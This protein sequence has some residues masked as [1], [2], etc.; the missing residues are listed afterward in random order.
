MKVLITGGTGNLGKEL[1]VLFREALAPTRA[2]L[3]ICN[4]EEIHASIAKTVPEVV[5]HTAALTG[6][7]ACEQNQRLAY[8][9]NVLGSKYL[10]EA[11]KK[12][13]RD[14]FFVHISTACV[15]AGDRGNY[16][17]S[18]VPYPKNFYSLTKLLSEFEVLHSGLKRWL[19]VRTNFVPRKRW[20]YPKAFV[21]RYGTYLFADDMARAL[22]QVIAEGWQGHIHVCGRDRL[23]MFE[24]AKITT[25]EVK[26][27][28]LREYEGPPLTAD[29]TLSSERIEPFQLSK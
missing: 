23:S 29:M 1:Q 2:E 17:E 24:L 28:T 11:C 9:T 13:S 25:P 18:D 3:D 5:I 14:C 27:M 10:V 8:Q 22:K 20:P 21:D 7:R 15:F 16:V 12:H 4:A 19:V 26:P 6:I